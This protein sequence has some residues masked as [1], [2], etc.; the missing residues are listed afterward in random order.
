MQDQTLSD[1]LR[2]AARDRD[3]AGADP[4][5]DAALMRKAAAELERLSARGPVYWL[6]DEDNGNEGETF[7]VAILSTA[8]TDAAIE[9]WARSFEALAALDYEREPDADPF[10]SLISLG[11]GGLAFH[12]VATTADIYNLARFDDNDYSARVRILSADGTAKLLEALAGLREGESL[13]VYKGQVIACAA[14][15]DHKPRELFDLWD[16]AEVVVPDDGETED[17]DDEEATT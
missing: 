14:G 3:F 6:I 7:G 12:R 1:R 2:A 16:F 8:E 9:K 17:T 15:D 5:G 13:E 11:D 4:H 10:D